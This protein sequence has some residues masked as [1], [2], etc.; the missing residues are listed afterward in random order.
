MLLFSFVFFIVGISEF[1]Y[2]VKKKFIK[3]LFI[4]T[5]L[6]ILVFIFACF[7]YSDPIRKSF[8]EIII[9]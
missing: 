8:L 3:D 1:I 5:I 6:M 7:Y 2:L 4:Y 9:R